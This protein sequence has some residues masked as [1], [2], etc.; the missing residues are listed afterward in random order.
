MGSA[1]VWVSLGLA[2]LGASSQGS[3]EAP[4]A[5]RETRILVFRSE[6]VDGVDDLVVRGTTAT[7]EHVEWEPIRSPTIEVLAGV[8]RRDDARIVV[9]SATGRPRVSVMQDPSAANEWVL[10]VRI[11][12]GPAARARPFDVVLVTLDS[13]RPDRLGAYG[14]GRPTSPTLDAFARTA[15]RYTNAY[16]TS[17]FTPPAHASM[18]TSRYVGDHGLRTWNALADEQLTLA[19]VLADHGYRT[20][21]SVNLALLSD[22]N[23][24]QGFAWRREGQRDAREIVD[25]ALEF[26][27]VRDARPIFLWLH[28]YDAHRPYGRV[29]GWSDRFAVDPRP[30]VG[31]REEDYNLERG[32]PRREALRE[33]DLAYVSDR[34]DG[35]IAY[36]DGELAPLFTELTR[37]VRLARTL[38]VVTADHGESLLDHAER[39]FTHDP[40]LF[41]AVTRVPLFVRRPAGVGAGVVRDDMVSSIDLGPTALALLGIGVPRSFQGRSLLDLDDTTRWTDRAVFQ[42]CWGWSRASAL[43]TSRWSVLLEGEE[44]VVRVFDRVAD[45]GELSALVEPPPD[46]ARALVEELRAFARRPGIDA[47]KPRLDSALRD[48]LRGLG[49]TDDR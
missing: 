42:E 47:G 19:E 46:P 21:A 4:S 37:P 12:D 5:P 41:D 6:A 39:Y 1:G 20:G 22:Q 45:P 14:H 29:P 48:R 9:R 38:V 25:D 7:L 24:G 8:P 23:L 44:D 11:D 40:F 33:A 28:F 32:A 35:G 13:L 43:R 27:R 17:S 34:Y 49:Y 31:D 16:G 2:G 3:G 10:R 36:L 26:L 30:G 15:T 18:L